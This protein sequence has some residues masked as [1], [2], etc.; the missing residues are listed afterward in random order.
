MHAQGKGHA[1]TVIEVGM[2]SQNH[3]Q[4]TVY[5]HLFLTFLGRQQNNKYSVHKSTLVHIEKN[6]SR[7][8]DHLSA[9]LV[10][11]LNSSRN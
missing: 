11:L 10:S 4:L 8:S 3:F 7:L 9:L 1:Y 2:W 5:S 6:I